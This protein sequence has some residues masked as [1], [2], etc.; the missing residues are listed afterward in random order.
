ML[1]WLKT[2][3]GEPHTAETW[4]KDLTVPTAECL[5]MELCK[6]RER[7]LSTYIFTHINRGRCCF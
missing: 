2:E 3:P 1:T 6:Y 7:S 5:H 4:L